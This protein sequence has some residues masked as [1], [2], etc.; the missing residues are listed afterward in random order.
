MKLE[1]YKHLMAAGQMGRRNV[2]KGAAGIGALAAGASVGT[3]WH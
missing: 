2:L 1:V 3:E